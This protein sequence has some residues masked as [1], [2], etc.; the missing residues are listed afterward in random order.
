MKKYWILLLC[1]FIFP[2]GVFAYS[3]QVFVGGNTIGI[4]VH[5]K[6][7]SI[8]GFYDVLGKSI[9]EDA[10]F[11]IG[12]IITRIDDQEIN[13]IS[14]LNQ[15]L[16]EDKTYS[17]HILRKNKELTIPLTVLE[18]TDL[19]K[20]GLYVKD[21]IHGIGT[22]SYIDPETKIF[23]SLGHEILE[24]NSMSRFSINSGTI[25]KAEVETILK[26][27][28]GSTG[29]KNAEVNYQEV[30]GSITLNELEGV[31]GIYQDNLSDLEIMDVGTIQ[32][33]KRGEATIKTVVKGNQVEDFSIK[34]LS[35]DEASD[36]KN[37]LFEITDSKLINKTGGIVQGMSGSPIIQNHKIIGVVNYVIV[38]DSKKGYGIF[39]TKM[40]E[41][42]DKVLFNH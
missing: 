3:N 11:K 30:L 20:T 22:L 24:S 33:I 31:F 13:S 4:E 6:G 15:Y 41:E 9:A 35:I 14:D 27:K 42:G 39:I 17:F 7:V 26:S 23:G 2:F 32:D 12:D 25:Y 37:I 1:I 34:I 5:G 40:L 36:N 38:D 18:D 21:Q 16:K 10:G 19:L 29:S 28:N 8:V